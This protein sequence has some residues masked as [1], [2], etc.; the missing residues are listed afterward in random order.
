MVGRRRTTGTWVTDGTLVAILLVMSTLVDLRPVTQ[1]AADPVALDR[2][3]VDRLR[4]LAASITVPLVAVGCSSTISGNAVASDGQF[5]T[6]RHLVDGATA[7]VLGGT[8]ATAALEDAPAEEAPTEAGS[9]G[10]NVTTVDLAAVRIAVPD[11][12]TDPNSG[13]ASLVTRDPAV[14]TPVLLAGWREGT[15]HVR[16]GRVHAY[17]YGDSYG[18]GRVM[19]LEP[20]TAPGFS[21]GPVLNQNGEIVGLLRAIDATTS[22]TVAIP[23]STIRAWR[24]VAKKQVEE[25]SCG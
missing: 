22:L 23:A 10:P 9:S 21:G 11:R 16:V 25:P 19:L 1:P 18:P 24:N 7:I 13:D 17:T 14:G 5:L 8:P 2:L 12:R 4:G 6:N 15:F 3:T 20:M